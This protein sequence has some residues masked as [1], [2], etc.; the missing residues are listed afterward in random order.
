MGLPG[1]TIHMENG[2][3]Y[4]DG[5]KIEEKYE[6]DRTVSS[7]RA[8]SDI[9][10][11][12]DEYFVLSDKRTDLDDSRSTSFTKVK[13]ENIIGPVFMRTTPLSLVTGPN[14]EE[15]KEEETEG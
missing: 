4:A 11:D 8:E 15:E 9:V 13:K 10:L 2:Y 5:V 6:F 1:E 7:G 3:I 12:D 14:A